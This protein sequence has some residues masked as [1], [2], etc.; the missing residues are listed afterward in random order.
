MTE[1]TP[2]FNREKPAIATHPF[3][4][5]QRFV[6]ST[7]QATFPAPSALLVNQHTSNLVWIDDIDGS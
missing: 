3:I 1:K 5:K 6:L 2:L 7:S 4:W